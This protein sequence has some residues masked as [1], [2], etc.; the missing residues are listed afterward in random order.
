MPGEA[1][2]GRLHK[3]YVDADGDIAAP[4]WVVYGKIQGA[5]RTGQRDVAE[6]KERDQEDTLAM[7]G[8]KNREI[9]VTV[10]KRPGDTNYDILQTAF[11]TGAKVGIAMMTGE[12]TTVGEQGY[13]A[14]MYVTGFEDPE[15]HDATTNVVTLRP[16]ADYTTPPAF[17]EITV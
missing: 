17:V 14:E 13:Q 6:V 1:R 3:F 10:T 9:S 8:H 2:I 16:C 4:M 15:E 12:I 7:L 5:S 11:E